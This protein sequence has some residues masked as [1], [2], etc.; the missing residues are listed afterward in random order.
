M[1][2]ALL[3]K[4]RSDIE[5]DSAGVHPAIPISGAAKEFLER[6]EAQE[7]LKQAPEGLENKKLKNYDLIVAM[8]DEHRDAI[9]NQCSQCVD[10]IVV[11]NID[12]PYFLPHRDAETIF[13]QIKERV[14][15]LA[16]SL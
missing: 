4:F 10:K 1:A 3:K 8:K 11:W 7:H 6:E 15:E 9:L 5:V 14:F 2:E 13:R 16:S 12:D